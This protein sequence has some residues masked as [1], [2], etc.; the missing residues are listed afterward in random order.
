LLKAKS[1][2]ALFWG[3]ASSWI[4][5]PTP[6]AAAAA[7]SNEDETTFPVAAAAG[8]LGD[9]RSTVPAF[10][11]RA[12]GRE[13]YTNSITASRD[14]N[15]SPREAYDVMRQ[16]VPVN[17]RTGS[18]ERRALDVGAGAGVSTA[19]LYGEMGY[20]CVD[21][22]DWSGEAW[23]GNVA[24]PIPDTVRFYPMDDDQFFRSEARP[25]SYHV[26]VYNF[27]VNA[28]KAVRV[29]RRYLVDEGDGGDEPRTGD[30][31]LL[32][33]P[34][35][36]RDD[37]WYKQTYWVINSKGQI[38]WKSQPEVGAWSVQFQ[39]DVTSETCT[40]IWCGGV[41]GYQPARTSR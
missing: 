36:D 25:K 31:G 18:R 33:A 28:D 32:L 5:S 21:A 2:A 20:R 6:A 12:Y 40:G 10:R 19:V 15:V 17:D 14:T 3:A 27:A 41:N 7:E 29:A 23:R 35:N 38:L 22:V 8:D 1:V 16:R 37:Y 11:T 30:G 4:S 26:I 34:V 13:E 39:P 24:E 9:R